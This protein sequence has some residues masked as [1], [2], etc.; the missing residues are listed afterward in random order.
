MADQ[1]ASTPW[2]SRIVLRDGTVTL[3]RRV[4][5]SDADGMLRFLRALSPM[6]VYLRFCSGGANL[7]RAVIDFTQACGDSV[8]I[9][10]CDASGEIVGHAEYVLTSA[11]RAEVAIVV[12]DRLQG[13]G[14]ARR[15][16]EWLAAD[17]QDHG[18]ERFIATVLPRNTPM[19]ALFRRAFGARVREGSM[20]CAVSFATAAGTPELRAA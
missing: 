2:G 14:L 18:I 9:V 16:I 6:S 12:A 8:G 10:A 5:P 4:R 15:M 13:R 11:G 20:M 19:L 1:L 17:A 7:R 3:V